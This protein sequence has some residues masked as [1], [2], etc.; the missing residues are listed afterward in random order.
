MDYKASV[1]YVEG[2]D[3]FGMKLGLETIKKLLNLM[4]NPQN[5]LKIIHVAGTNGKGSTAN[6]IYEILKNSGYKVGLFTSPHLMDFNEKIRF[7]G[8]NISNEDFKEVTNDV[9]DQIQELLAQGHSHP[10]Q[11]EVLTAIALAFYQRKNADYVILEVGMGGRLDSTNVIDQ[12]L[13]S[14]ITPIDFDHSDYLGDTLAKIAT[15]KAGIIK[16]DSLVVTAQQADE[17][18]EVIQAK[19]KDQNS[20]LKIVESKNFELLDHSINGIRFIYKTIEYYL[21]MIGKYQIENAILAIEAIHMLKDAIDIDVSEEVMINTL[22]DSQWAGRFEILEKVPYLIIDGAHNLQGA[23]ALKESM[24]NLFPDQKILGVM[25]MLG[26]KDVNGVIE[27]LMPLLTEVYITKPDNSRAM[28]PK[29][30]EQ[31][32]KKFNTHTKVYEAINDCV[33]AVDKIKGNFDVVIYFG[34]LYMIGKVRQIKKG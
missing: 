27:E 9:Y 26:D 8:Q 23:K 33:E 6:F 19:A 29:A 12:T 17:V 1:D 3:K 2:L 28:A 31:K 11:F 24:I 20:K 16:K 34:S 13:L 32:V 21:S 7:D 30:L 18:L 5:D 14:V 25:G 22:K 10:T 4:D 15:E